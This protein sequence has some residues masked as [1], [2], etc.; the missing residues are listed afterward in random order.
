MEWEDAWRAYLKRLDE[1]KPVIFCGDFN[2]AHQE[3]D[4]KNPKTNRNNA[5]FSDQERGKFTDFWQ[6][7]LPTPGGI[8]IRNRRHLFLVVLPFKAREKK[9][10]VADRL[11]LRI[12]QL[13][14]PAGV[15]KDPYRGVRLRSLSG[16]TV[17]EIIEHAADEI[18][19]VTG[20]AGRIGTV[21]D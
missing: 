18:Q 2:V 9:R 12:R 5:G 10:G 7:D 8:F 6:P 15:G 16:G 20:K 13:K 11:F 21:S 4:L 3:I 1:K 19:A 17:P 14:R